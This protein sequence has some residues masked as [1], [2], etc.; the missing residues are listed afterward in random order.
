LPIRAG[1][2]RF[3][4]NGQAARATDA[5]GGTSTLRVGDCSRDALAYMKFLRTE[6]KAGRRPGPQQILFG[7]LYEVRL[8]YKGTAKVKSGDQL[9]ETDHFEFHVKG[10]ASETNFEA[11]FARDSART[12]VKF[13]V[14][15]SLGTFTMDLI[16][17]PE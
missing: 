12:P 9:I 13:V 3:F 1:A 14:P 15:T 16:R 5:G 6:L 2:P 10:P 17:Q 11:N 4:S 8:V 7:A